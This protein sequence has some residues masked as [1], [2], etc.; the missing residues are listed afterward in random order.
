MNSES[1]LGLM[2][3]AVA[4][5]SFL[6]LGAQPPDAEWGAMTAGT[7]GAGTVGAGT[8]AAATVALS[9]PRLPTVLVQSKGD[10]DGS[11]GA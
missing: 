6:G 7:M 1:P 9:T 8:V 3:L 5:H 10:D 2:V 4:G 11:G